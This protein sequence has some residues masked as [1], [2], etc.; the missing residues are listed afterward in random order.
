M[1]LKEYWP[2]FCAAWRLKRLP[3]EELMRFADQPLPIIVTLTSIPSR[4][5]TLH[6]TLRSLLAQSMKPQKIVLWLHHDLEPQLPLSLSE[7]QGEIFEIRYVD[8]TCSHRKLIYSLRI[9]PDQVLVT[10]DDDLLYHNTWLERLYNDHLRYPDAVIA[11]ECRRITRTPEGELLPY[12]QWPTQTETGVCGMD[13]LPIGY[14]GVLYPPGALMQ[15]VT[16]VDLFMKLAPKA[17]DLWF[18]AMSFLKGTLV[19]RSSVPC[20]KPLPLI[21][22]QKLSLRK[23]N[24]REDANRVQWEVLCDYFDIRIN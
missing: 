9:F 1:K 10:C 19:R 12:K 16:D 6:L 22:T 2:S 8:L 7:L 15:D 14:G 13:L 3:L 23:T 5:N 4:L 24:V 18:K 17:D 11:H 21:G 20:P